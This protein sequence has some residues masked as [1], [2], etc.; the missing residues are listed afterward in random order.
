MNEFNHT[1]DLFFQHLFP[2]TSVSETGNIILADWE[3]QFVA[4]VSPAG[5]LIQKHAQNG[6]GPGEIQLI[7]SMDLNNNNLLLFDQNRQRI[8]SKHLDENSV[9][10]YEF[11]NIQTMMPVEAFFTHEQKYL[12]LSFWDLTFHSHLDASP[13]MAFGLL[14]LDTNN[15]ENMAYYPG[16]YFARYIFGQEIRGATE[17]PFTPDLLFG[18]SSDN[19]SLFV[20]HTPGPEIVKLDMMSFDTLR[21][22]PLRLPSENI[23]PQ[24]FDSLSAVYTGLRWNT[25]KEHLPEFKMPVDDLLIDHRNRIWLQLTRFSGFREWLVIDEN[26]NPEAIARFPK[27]TRLSHLSKY[28]IGAIMDDSSVAL[29]QFPDN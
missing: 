25:I 22:I 18:K 8:I 6:Y 3:G 9:E 7:R 1:E 23:N 20:Y 5:E 11:K 29:F 10:E 13:E 19:R 2:R 14:N 28:H 12:L 16:K 21:S 15:I 17:V 26:G 27:D 4:E 24:E